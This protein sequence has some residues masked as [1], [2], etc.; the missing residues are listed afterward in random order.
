[1][2]K[3]RKVD[4]SARKDAQTL[5]G[6]AAISDVLHCQGDDEGD[7]AVAGDGGSGDGDGERDVTG[8]VT[9]AQLKALE[10]QIQS[11][12]GLVGLIRAVRRR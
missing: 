9:G 8:W 11:R 6:P 2:A 10:A 1:M 12:C 7:L 5:G 4:K 3:K